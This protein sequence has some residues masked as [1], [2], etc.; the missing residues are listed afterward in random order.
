LTIPQIV[1]Q[2]KLANNWKDTDDGHK[3]LTI[4][5]IV[6]QDRLANNWK[7]TDDGHKVLTI[8][9]IVLQ[10]RL[11]NNWKDTEDIEM[12][13][14][15]FKAIFIYSCARQYQSYYRC[16]KKCLLSNF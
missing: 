6:L 9:Q 4:S 14:L 11:A 16:H 1:L 7:D 12:L 5:Q 2:A 3:V 15:N 13:A 10:D 8:S